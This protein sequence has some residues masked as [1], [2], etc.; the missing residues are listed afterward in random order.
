MIDVFAGFRLGAPAARV[1]SL[2]NWTGVVALSGA[3][4]FFSAM[5]LSSSEPCVGARRYFTPAQG[6]PEI[7][8][9]LLHYDE[10]LRV[11]TYRVVDA[12]TLPLADYEGRVCVTAAGP[13][14]CLL[15]FSARGIPVGI[16]EQQ[17][18]DFY[19]AAESQIAAAVAKRLGA[20][21]L[22]WGGDES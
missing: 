8:E 18:R 1:W 3:D 9:L 6:G 16:T 22:C 11:Y 17:F 12:G 4:T 15:S 2:I 19:Q 21:V 5:R 14:Q 10:Q 7:E 20:R 13:D